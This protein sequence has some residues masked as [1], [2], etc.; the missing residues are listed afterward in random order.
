M[1]G[2]T[3]SARTRSRVEEFSIKGDFGLKRRP[4]RRPD[5]ECAPLVFQ[6]YAVKL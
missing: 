1:K 6:I 3:V 5:A 2:K 4:E